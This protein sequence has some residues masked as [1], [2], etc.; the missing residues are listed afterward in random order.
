ML[1]HAVLEIGVIA[2]LEKD[3][4][5]FS[6]GLTWGQLML[7]H[8]VFSIILLVVGLVFGFRQGVYWWDKLYGSKSA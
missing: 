8:H 3:F 4:A 7:V 6:L 5:K 2:L 1:A